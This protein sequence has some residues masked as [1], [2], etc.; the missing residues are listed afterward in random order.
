MAATAE[1]TGHRGTDDPLLG[2]VING[3]YRVERSIARGGMGRIYYATQAPLDR[4]VALKVVRADTVDEEQSQFL[5]RFLLEASILAKLQHPNIVTLFDYGRIENVPVEMYFIA[6]EYLNGE[7]LNQRL[8]NVGQLAPLD[9]LVAFR[10]IARGLR[11]AHARGVIH[12]DLKPAN[13]ILL[14]HA[15][16]EIVKLVDFGIGKEVEKS[17]EDLTADGVLVGTPRYMAPEQFGGLSSPASDVYSLGV[18]VFQMLAGTS[19]YHGLSFTDLVGAKLAQPVPYLREMRPDLILPTTLEQLVY[20]MMARQQDDRPPLDEIFGLLGH[21]EEEILGSSGARLSL[22]GRGMR[23]PNSSQ[24]P[25][26]PAAYVSPSGS[27][28]PAPGQSGPYLHH[29]SGPHTGPFPLP[30]GP[31]PSLP[32]GPF[33]AVSGSVPVGY[34]QHIP[35]GAPIPSDVMPVHMMPHGYASVTPRPMTSAELAREQRKPYGI[36]VAALLL[37]LIGGGAGAFL[38]QRGKTAGAEQ[39]TA[40]EPSNKPETKA[41]ASAQPVATTFVLHLDTA[42]SGAQVTDAE[43][44]SLGTTPLDLDIDRAEAATTPRSFSLKKEG[45]STVLVSQGTADGDVKQTVTLAPD[46]NHSVKSQPQQHGGRPTPPTTAKPQGTPG[47][48]DIRLKR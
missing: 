31:Y 19:P 46:P 44:K 28:A 30:T 47:D 1:P 39:P 23:V 5:R 12:R 11:E 40:T 35:Q 26:A 21:C 17:G 7:T 13:I 37:L 27:F 8:K 4:P 42:P 2:S 25:F 10:Q 29:D 43:G 18:I 16:G 41:S 15:D 36:M 48:N 20:R 33:Q 6:M 24:T 14:P 38:Y 45:F 3:K 32:T 22:G 34:Y 9:A